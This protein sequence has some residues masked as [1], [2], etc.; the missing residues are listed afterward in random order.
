LHPE[1]YGAYNNRGIAYQK[2]GQHNLAIADF[3]KAIELYPAFV[4][5]YINR[6]N[7]HQEVGEYESSVA[8][9][10]KAIELDPENSMAYNNR[11]FTFILM[12]RYEDAER[13]IRRS[14]ELSPNNI[15][16]LNSMAELSASKNDAPE[17]CAWLTLAIE[18]GYNWSYI[19]SSRTYDSIRDSLC[20]K[21]IIS[22]I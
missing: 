21:K 14:L 5:A 9:L 19:R 7:A 3:T 12:G 8:D 13:D 2:K 22:R 20:F 1:S 10:N 11:G 17:A 6:G 4:P 18:K 15:Y 16:A